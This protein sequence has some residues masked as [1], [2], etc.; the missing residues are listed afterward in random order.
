MRGTHIIIIFP[1][2]LL[3]FHYNIFSTP[4]F[5]SSSHSPCSLSYVNIYSI[6]HT[7]FFLIIN[8][9]F[10]NDETPPPLL[11]RADTMDSRDQFSRIPTSTVTPRT[12]TRPAQA[13]T[14]AAEVSASPAC[15]AG[16]RFY[17]VSTGVLYFLSRRRCVQIDPEIIIP[18]GASPLKSFCA[19]Y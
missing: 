14:K 18:L 1:F 7:V 15:L 2:F 16:E 8:T 9:Y 19:N 5:T 13:S 12:S 3:F 10:D 17:I 11:F 6:Y 4:F